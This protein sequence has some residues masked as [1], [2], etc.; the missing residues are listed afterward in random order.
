[1]YVGVGSQTHPTAAV[2]SSYTYSSNGFGSEQVYITPAQQ[3]ANPCGY[4][5]RYYIGVT[6]WPTAT[7][8]TYHI[9]AN[10]D[11]SNETTVLIDGMPQWGHAAAHTLQLYMVYVPADST[12]LTVTSSVLMGAT[13]LYASNAKDSQGQPIPMQRYCVISP[14]PTT[15]SQWS[16]SGAQWNSQ[17]TTNL[18]NITSASAGWCSDC[19]YTIGVF[20][21]TPQTDTAGSDYIVTAI[22]SANAHIT[23]SA[24]VTETGSVVANAY[25]YYKL[26]ISPPYGPVQVR[27]SIGGE[28]LWQLQHIDAGC[29][30]RLMLLRSPVTLTST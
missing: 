14:T 30:R 17:Q 11:T 27:A 21:S 15:C 7:N 13:T 25:V 5:C 29:R 24:G 20:A 3:V 10:V 28:L 16:V 19:H 8:A 23:L 1:M 6:S 22:R 12:S 2:L 18:L 9:V 4:P 26:L